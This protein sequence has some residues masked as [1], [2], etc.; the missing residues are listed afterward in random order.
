A[1]G[2]DPN[3]LAAE[4]GSGHNLAVVLGPSNL[5]VLEA[6][7]DEAERELLGLLGGD[8]PETPALRTGRGF[9]H[10]YFAATDGLRR[11][12]RAGLELRAGASLCLVPPSRHP[13]T[14]AAYAWLPGHEPWHIPPAPL[15]E[16][17]VSYFR[18]PPPGGGAA[19][20]RPRSRPRSPRSTPAAARRRF[21]PTRS[22]RSPSRW[23]TT[24][25]VA[26]PAVAGHRPPTSSSRSR[27][28]GSSCTPRRR[29]RRSPCRATARGSRAS[30]G[31]AARRCAPSWR[32]PT[33]THTAACRPQQRWR[34][35]FSS[36]KARRRPGRR[37]NSIF[38]L[39]VRSRSRLC[40]IS[41]I[42]AAG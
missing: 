16:A 24:H 6:D 28:L 30:S 4:L 37:A 41:V 31:A 21:P 25:P 18:A 5:A 32:P 34:T 9:P 22:R 36:S 20:V 10:V 38:E 35:R 3:A 12:A 39:R 2:G 19:F 14:G 29:A 40:S 27:V 15:P 42:P 26:P 1:P 8:L 7:T 23:R 17:V 11:R 33:R 13:E